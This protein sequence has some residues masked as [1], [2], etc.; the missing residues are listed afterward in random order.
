[1]SIG[2]LRLG[3]IDGWTTLSWRLWLAAEGNRALS[4]FTLYKNYTLNFFVDFFSILAEKIEQENYLLW[5]LT[6]LLITLFL[7]LTIVIIL[8]LDALILQVYKL[9][10]GNIVNA[11]ENG[12]QNGAIKTVAAIWHAHARLWHGYEV[13]GLENLP[14]TGGALVIYYHGAIPIDLYYFMSYVFL[15]KNRLVYTVA[16]KF[17]FKV[18]GFSIIAENLK[19][20]PGTVQECSSILKADNILAISPGGVYEAQFGDSY[21]QL[22][23]KNRLGFAKAAIDAKRPIIPMFTQNIRE[24]FVSVTIGRKFWLKLYAWTRYPLAPILGGFPVKLRTYIGKPISH[25]STTPDQL[26][27]KV[28]ESLNA[29]IAEHQRIPGS[30]TRALFERIYIPRKSKAI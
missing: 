27:T 25:E 2:R 17:L 8:Y 23:W 24:A 22:L 13:V 4:M 7:P 10:W 29:M 15:N 12:F 28:A 26:R 6:P 18:P 9:H 30:I 3:V 19:V 16:D 1:M 5:A 21:Y 20:I 11:Y 14:D